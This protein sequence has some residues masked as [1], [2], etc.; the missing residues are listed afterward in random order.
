MAGHLV[1]GRNS[2]STQTPTGGAL[3]TLDDLLPLIGGKT[4]RGGYNGMSAIV[5]RCPVCAAA[6]MDTAGNHL[7]AYADAEWIHFCRCVLG[8]DENEVLSALGCEQEDRRIVPK[9]EKV[10]GRPARPK[11]HGQSWTYVNAKGHPALLKTK[12]YQWKESRPQNGVPARAEGWYKEFR[13]KAPDDKP[14]SERGRKLLYNLPT[15]IEAVKSG[16]TI[17]I[18][19]GEKACD[20]FKSLGAVSTCQPNG[21]G[22]GTNLEGKWTPFHTNLLKGAKKVVIVADRDKPNEKKV[23]VGEAYARYIA[24]QLSDV[25]DEIEIVQSKTTGDKDDAWDHFQAGFGLIDF[26]PRP[27][28]LPPLDLDLYSFGEEFTPVTLEHIVHPYLPKGKC[29]LFDADGGVGKTTMALQWAAALSR[30]V[31]PLDANV[32]LDGGPVKTLYL[33]KGEDG[34]DELET[35]Y[36]ANGGVTGMLVFVNEKSSPGL[37]FDPEGLGKIKRA[38]RRENFGLVIVDALFYFLE[39]LVGSGYDALDVMPTIQRMNDVARET[40]ATFWN[41]RHTTKGSIGTAA[42]NL[43]MGSTAFRNSHRGQLVAR[44][45][46]EKQGAVVVTDEKGSLLNPKGEFFMFRRV[47]HAVEYILDQPNPFDKTSADEQMLAKAA[48]LDQAKAF[49][50]SKLTGEWVA[51]AD[52]ISEGAG[53]GIARRTIERARSLLGVQ[54]RTV[55]VGEKNVT[56]LHIPRPFQEEDPYAEPD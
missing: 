17:Y 45:H 53:Q 2:R 32:P 35:V 43:G 12:L 39:G 10:P 20:C 22:E 15:V 47:G 14:L 46:P 41:V 54:C 52:V 5:G 31:H 38:I 50:R 16:A 19:E 42:S 11:D 40:G 36:R 44:L 6:G 27:D 7:V 34:S 49:L 24:G 9:E 26:V 33:H 55:T 29:V 8:H 56:Y 13:Q 28:L 25:V 18:N 4:K 3:L 1:P 21:A 37:K 23:V 30:G 48:K 51:T